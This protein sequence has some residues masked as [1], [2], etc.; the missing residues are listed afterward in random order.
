MRQAKLVL[1]IIAG[2]GLAAIAAPQDAPAGQVFTLAARVKWDP[3]SVPAGTPGG[4]KDIAF[5][6]TA[7][8]RPEL[9]VEEPSRFFT[10]LGR[11]P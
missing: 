11:R 1:T 5:T 7:Q 3:D 6:L 4:A 2:F 10:P 8:D 9:T